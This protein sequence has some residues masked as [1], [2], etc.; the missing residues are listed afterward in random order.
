[1]DIIDDLLFSSSVSEKINLEP[2]GKEKKF[3]HYFAVP[4]INGKKNPYF[5]KPEIA[6][7][8][9][10]GLDDLKACKKEANELL[11]EEYILRYLKKIIKVQE[12]N[13]LNVDKEL[14]FLVGQYADLPT[15]L[16]AI[17]EYNK[18]KG[19][20][21]EKAE[22]EHTFKINIV[23]YNKP[24]EQS[25]IEGEKTNDDSLFLTK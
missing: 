23:D 5:G 10:T 6:F 11:K 19:R 24:K 25:F 12:L 7:Q 2:S 22:M 13:D 8:E 17:R 20:V 15:K 3:C 18:L 1:M 21:A 9:A 16:G 14:A 4:E